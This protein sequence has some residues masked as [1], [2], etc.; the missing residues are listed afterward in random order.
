MGSCS[1]NVSIEMESGIKLLVL[2]VRKIAK[3]RNEKESKKKKKK[4]II[5]IGLLCN[6]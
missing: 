6:R 1:L 5:I 3:Q 4:N 2:V